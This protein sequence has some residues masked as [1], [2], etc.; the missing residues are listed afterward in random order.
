MFGYSQ[1]FTPIESIANFL[2]QIFSMLLI[3]AKLSRLIV[4]V[5]TNEGLKEKQKLMK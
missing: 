3:F 4:C 1:T 2:Y 5:D